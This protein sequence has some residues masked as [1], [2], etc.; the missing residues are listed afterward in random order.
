MSKGMK[1]IIFSLLFICIVG[2]VLFVNYYPHYYAFSQTPENK[3]YSGQASWFD[4]WDINNYFAMI[5]VSQKNRSLLLSNINTTESMRPALIYPLYTSIATIFPHADNILLYHSLAILCGLL[6]AI[7]I[8]VLSN[9]FVKKP[10]YSLYTLLIISLGGGLGFLF[11]APDMSADLHIPGVTFLSSFQKP[12]E[13]VATLLYISSLVYFYFSIE[14]KKLSHLWISIALF[15]LLIPIYPYR[16]LSFLLIVS[17][18]AAIK[19]I[20]NQKRYPVLY[21][22][23]FSAMIVPPTILYTIHFLHSGFSVLT[24]YQPHQVTLSSLI[25]GYGFFFIFFVYQLFFS[26]NKSSAQLFLNIWILVSIGLAI[27]PFGMSRLYLSGLLFPMALLFV[28]SLKNLSHIPNLFIYF[29][30]MLSLIFI[31]PTSFYTYH[32]RIEEVRSDNIWFYIPTSYQQ[33]LDFLEDSEMDGVLALPPL[34]SY[35][36]AR[37]GKHVYFG[38]KDQS[39]GYDTKLAKAENFYSGTLSE[40]K[41]QAFLQENNINLVVVPLHEVQFFAHSYPFLTVVYKNKDIEI[42][43]R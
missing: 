41:A 33:S 39:P 43:S 19:G 18:F 40:T 21:V 27:V 28:L 42:L 8:F 15:L 2:I 14:R 11:S 9:M 5:K 38:I 29:M 1:K 24:S 32:K 26:K 3:S 31:L 12:H 22:G 35:I 20:R 16:L 10:L 4:P 25:F 34:S 23:I 6:L 37:T 36:P 13:A 17:L 7:G 30:M